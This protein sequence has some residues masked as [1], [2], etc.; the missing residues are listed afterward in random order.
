M[1]N[2]KVNK[3]DISLFLSERYKN[4]SK[5]ECEDIINS[6]FWKITEEI[7]NDNIVSIVGFGQ[8]FQKELGERIATNPQNGKK[9]KKP[10]RKVV[11]FKIGTDLKKINKKNTQ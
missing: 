11:K 10:K 1:K 6:L 7:K 3:K 8:F 5:S 2:E 9:F 4:L